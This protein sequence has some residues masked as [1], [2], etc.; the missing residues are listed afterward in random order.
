MSND[1]TNESQNER[2]RVGAAWFTAGLGV[3]S[4]ALSFGL[5]VEDRQFLSTAMRTEGIV[6]R[7][8]PPSDPRRGRSIVRYHVDSRVFEIEYEF[9]SERDGTAARVNQKVTVLYAEDRPDKGRVERSP[10]RRDI[11]MTFA[12]VS[13]VAFGLSAFCFFA[14]RFVTRVNESREGGTDA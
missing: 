2:G 11:V 1:R 7:V 10:A 3:L 6:T 5:W 4:I 13:L 8:D 12:I 9:A 14:P